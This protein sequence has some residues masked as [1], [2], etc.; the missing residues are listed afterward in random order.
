M[1]LGRFLKSA[2]LP[3][4]F[5][6]A[7]RPELAV[8]GRSNSGKS[9]LINA[10]LGQVKVAKISGTPGKTR[11]V[12]FFD[13]GDHYR[14]VD[15]PGYGFAARP[16]DERV[17]WEEM[18][19]TYLLQRENLIGLLLVCD[20]RRSWEAEEELIAELARNRGFEII[21]LLNKTDK[22]SRKEREAAQKSWM[23]K[24]GLARD[25]FW[26][27]SARTGSEIEEL[28]RHVFKRWVSPRIKK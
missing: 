2:V 24:S 14:L 11:L 21:C 17:M 7:D 18:I 5:P 13:A 4:D 12:N 15:L 3:S 19:R 22:L 16:R 28:E 9:T 26:F 1:P 8:V 20:V 25:Q 6:P 27:I 10:L 23:G